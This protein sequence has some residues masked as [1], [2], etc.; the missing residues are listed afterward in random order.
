MD[1]VVHYICDAC[2]LVENVVQDSTLRTLTQA[3]FSSSWSFAGG[4]YS[5]SDPV[6]QDRSAGGVN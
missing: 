2:K 5:D 1:P 6:L 4:A 3:N